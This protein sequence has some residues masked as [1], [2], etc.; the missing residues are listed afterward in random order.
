MNAR[1]RYFNA[2]CAGDVAAM[3]ELL[4]ASADPSG[5]MADRTYTSERR[6][7]Y[8]ALEAAVEAGHADTV[9]FMLAHPSSDAMMM[10]TAAVHAAFECATY[11]WF[12]R[13]PGGAV[14][15]VRALLDD[16][17]TCET[18]LLSRRDGTS[19]FDSAVQSSPSDV[20]G[21]LLD[22]L[23]LLPAVDPGVIL[24]GRNHNGGTLL[25]QAVFHGCV[26]SMRLILDALDQ[27]GL[28]ASSAIWNENDDDRGDDFCAIAD[29]ARFARC[30]E[31]DPPHP[32]DKSERFA[33]LLLVLR[34]DVL[35][36]PE[37]ETYRMSAVVHALTRLT[38]L[39]GPEVIQEEQPEGYP[40]LAL[41]ERDECVRLLL[42]RGAPFPP[43]PVVSRINREVARELRE[44]AFEL[45]EL[46]RAP[47]ALNEA[48]V[49]MALERERRAQ[50]V[51]EGAS[52]GRG[53]RRADV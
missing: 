3:R 29:A 30:G 7:Q 52:R 45:A 15:I 43:G 38:G 53:G 44:V 9:D 17:R 40:T 24:A 36:P 4:C 26:G 8:S 32:P 28:G 21:L 23:L 50:L 34:R 5:M 31:M 25:L 11:T 47:Q 48:T 10:D 27:L 14:R 46:R 20:V 13:L 37:Y 35:P 51:G 18:A 2:A 6:T 19:V 16:P 49:S 41:Q 42:A 33:P 39:A 22:R 12:P 1:S